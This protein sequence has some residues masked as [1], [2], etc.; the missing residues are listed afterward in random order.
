MV[1]LEVVEEVLDIATEN[2]N[3]T[4]GREEAVDAH[5]A[6]VAGPQVP[7]TASQAHL[8][9]EGA[10]GVDA[11]ISG[12]PGCVLSRHYLEHSLAGAK[13]YQIMSS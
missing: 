13:T 12:E 6:V 2:A 7:S 10:D 8:A 3:V 5:L 9:V 11:S 1:L 4:R